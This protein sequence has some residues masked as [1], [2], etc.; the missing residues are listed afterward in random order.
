MLNRPCHPTA[1]VPNLR[2]IVRFINR[3]NRKYSAESAINH[4]KPYSGG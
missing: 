2:A 3:N 1:G 4:S